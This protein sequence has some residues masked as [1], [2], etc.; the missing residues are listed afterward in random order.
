MTGKFGPRAW[1]RWAM[2]GLALY[3][4]NFA[5]TFHNVWP[6]PWI[7]TW[8]ELSVD[9]A[10]I[11]LLI[12]AYTSFVG[13]LSSRALN[14]LAA[15]LL[16]MCIGRYA[17]VTA[18]ALYGRRINLYWDAQYLPD[19][20]AMLTRVASPWLIGLGA[21][22]LAAL[23]GAI[24]A[25]LRWC[26]NQVR[27]A[28][29][30]AAARRALW[31]LSGGLVAVYA[32]GYAPLPVDTLHWFSLPV[33]QTYWRQA[34]FVV[35]AVEEARDP[36]TLPPSRSFA[37]YDL[38]RVAGADVFLI[39][40]ESYGAAVFDTPSLNRRVAAERDE[41]T[42]SIEAS[43]RH[44]VSAFVES[45]T[46]GGGSWLA[47]STL[48]TGLPI[49]DNGRYNLLL[50]QD[51]ASLPK[52]F[53]SAGYRT[54]ALMPG[55]KNAWP[56]G[57][58]YHFAKVYAMR[59]LDYRGP[60]FG[61]WRIPDQY[62]LAALDAREVAP[63]GR[64]PL[65]VFYPTISTHIPFHPTPPYQPQWERVLGANP[66]DAGELA[67]SLAEEPDWTNLRDAYGDSVAYTYRYLSG[68]LRQRADAGAVFILIGDHQPAA[69]VSGVGARWDVPV[70][71]VTSRKAVLDTL[72]RE[73]FAAG[74]TP[75][76]AAIG[77]MQDLT[78][79]LL[80]A[81]SSPPAVHSS[82]RR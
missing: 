38:S 32:A 4:L 81:F 41:L 71:V 27:D 23:L 48:M 17:E 49:D 67:A 6:T 3:G 72:R 75:A 66:F 28:L 59:D 26:L 61:W 44:A 30:V 42:E 18:P 29:E 1:W 68:Y 63:R 21:V 11:V 70:H 33:T 73:G 37:G 80:G 54:I 22:A 2:L 9:V 25:A 56:E 24:Y 65:F 40:L 52:R 20:A 16:A 7:T 12:T 8:N 82:L 62:S 46:F 10:A 39:F 43:G 13:P 45:P 58:F 53:A 35:D 69:S 19:V 77:P 31:L 78:G 57:S 64:A 36:Q 47:H 55:L 50:T 5:V 15:L 51:R 74:L 79:I 14:G 76:A 60:E 34:E